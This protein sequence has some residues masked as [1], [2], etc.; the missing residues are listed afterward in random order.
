MLIMVNP[1]I[2]K[3]SN[4][5][6]SEVEGCLSVKGI[7]KQVRRNENVSVSFQDLD[8]DKVNMML[9]RLSSRIVQ[10]EIDHLDGIFPPR[11]R[12]RKLQ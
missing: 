6:C 7:T 12:K 1:V 2:T 5:K 10:H 3:R 4:R 8:G 11:K 9:N